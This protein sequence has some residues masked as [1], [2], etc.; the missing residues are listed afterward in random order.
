MQPQVRLKL[1]ATVLESIWSHRTL[2]VRKNDKGVTCP[3]LTGTT[4]A[5]QTQSAPAHTGLIRCQTTR[6][7]DLCCLKRISEW[8][9]PCV[10]KYFACILY[11]L[12]CG[13]TLLIL[14]NDSKNVHLTLPTKSDML[15]VAMMRMG[16]HS[17]KVGFRISD[18]RPGNRHRVML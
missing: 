17:P 18:S 5:N 8:K 10:I 6:I 13:N 9:W 4:N 15:K 12:W 16:S 7:F 14:L 11:F 1:G 2:C 3:A